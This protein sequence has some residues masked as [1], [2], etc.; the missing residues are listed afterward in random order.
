ME[1]NKYI[2]FRLN[3]TL[4]KKVKE[5]ADKYDINISHAIRYLILGGLDLENEIQ[6]PSVKSFLEQNIDDIVKIH[7]NKV[8]Q[9]KRIK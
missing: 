8:P 2:G 1:K 7:N 4:Y 9:N 3:D 6:M 5:T